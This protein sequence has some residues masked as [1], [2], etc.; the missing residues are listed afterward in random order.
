M[1]FRVDFNQFW[2]DPTE[3]NSTEKAEFRELSG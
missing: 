1:F 2:I 3:I